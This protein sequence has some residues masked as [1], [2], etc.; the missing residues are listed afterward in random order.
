MKNYFYKSILVPIICCIFFCGMSPAYGQKS[1]QSVAVAGL[2]YRIVSERYAEVCAPPAGLGTYTGDITIPDSI[3]HEGKEYPVSAIEPCAFMDSKIKELQLN[4]I[5][6]FINNSVFRNSTLT[7]IK[8]GCT[9]YLHIEA[10]AF[11]NC[12]QLEKVDLGGIKELYI[13]SLCETPTSWNFKNCVSLKE[14]VIHA[15]QIDTDLPD[16]IFCCSGYDEATNPIYQNCVVYMPK[17]AI[18]TYRKFSPFKYFRTIKAVEELGGIDD[19]VTE[20]EPEVISKRYYDL[21][22]RELMTAPEHGIYAERTIYSDG[23]AKVHKIAR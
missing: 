4:D 14:F 21:W 1:E 7:S 12:R 5:L 15:E 6:N 20:S 19:M 22:G 16:S 11:E 9:Q 3:I 23:A 8:T 2:Y 18:N 13:G 17:A 10:Y